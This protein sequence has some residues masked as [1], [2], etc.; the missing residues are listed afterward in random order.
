M[1]HH[2]QSIQERVIALAE[3]GNLTAAEA[4]RRYGAPDRTARRW[5]ERRYR[6][7]GETIRRAGTGF[8]RVS[9]QAEDARL[10]D[11]A[12]ENPFLKS[13][14]LKRNT[15]FPCCPRTVRKAGLRSRSA[16]VKEKL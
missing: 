3:E 10:V 2:N 13:V 8:W 7:T 16:A 14:Q 5:L 9:S 15:A 4:G 12:R 1:P 6:E 11:V